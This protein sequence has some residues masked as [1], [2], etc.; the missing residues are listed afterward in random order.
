[1]KPVGKIEEETHL[2]DL[3]QLEKDMELELDEEAVSEP[4]AQPATVSFFQQPHHAPPPRGK[5]SK[6]GGKPQAVQSAFFPGQTGTI[7]GK[8]G[9]P[10]PLVP[11]TY[12]EKRR[13]LKPANDR[14]PLSNS[15]A[16][17]KFVA[18]AGEGGSKFIRKSLSA[19][20]ALGAAPAKLLEELGLFRYVKERQFNS[21][22][23]LEKSLGQGH[24]NAEQFLRYNPRA[25]KKKKPDVPVT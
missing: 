23:R 16:A 21:L 2:V 19:L 15:T 24:E 14:M 8:W 7:T 9:E 25:L 3:D 17:S 6:F 12:M 18:Q 20:R 4:Q 1:M 10:T 22:L 5:K 11:L 13:K